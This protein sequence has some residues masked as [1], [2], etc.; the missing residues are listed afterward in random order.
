MA[1]ITMHAEHSPRQQPMSFWSTANTISID[2]LDFLLGC[3]WLP[4]SATMLLQNDFQY[5]AEQPNQ[6]LW[7]NHFN[8]P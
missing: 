8:C 7:I 4:K 6:Q 1:F 2:R 5:R 3:K